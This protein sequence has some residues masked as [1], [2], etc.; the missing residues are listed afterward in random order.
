MKWI[1]CHLVFLLSASVYAATDDYYNFKWLSIDKNI[2]V[3]Q[4]KYF[5][6][7]R[8]FFINGGY[9]TNGSSD[10][11]DSS[12]FHLSA[13]FFFTETW[14]LEGFMNSYSNA[15]N[16]T[17]E[18]IS[19]SRSL[20]NQQT[21][22]PN[23]RR[24]T[25]I[26]GFT[27]LYSP[28][29]GKLNTFNKILYLELILGAGAGSISAENNIVAFENFDPNNNYDTES[30]SSFHWKLQ[31]RVNVTRHILFNFDYYTYYFSAADRTT[32]AAYLQSTSDVIF[33]LG[34]TIWFEFLFFLFLV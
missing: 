34:F 5:S 14:G 26:T 10:F 17:Y 22:V 25:Q 8:S 6:K 21:V 4:Q 27:L 30:L 16:E 31:L 13:G 18:K 3:L 24:F 12:A 1:I 2:F 33:S 11:Q 28:F 19:A 9:G 32:E 29:Y 23:I 7:K 20:N 15:D